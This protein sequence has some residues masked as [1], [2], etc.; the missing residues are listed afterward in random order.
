MTLCL[1]RRAAVTC[2][3]AI[4]LIVNCELPNPLRES[5]AAFAVLRLCTTV[6]YMLPVQYVVQTRLLQLADAG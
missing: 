2:T 6:D 3:I 5:A 1:A 4:S